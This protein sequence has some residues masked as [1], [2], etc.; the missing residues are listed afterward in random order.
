MTDLLKM[1]NCGRAYTGIDGM[2]VEMYLASASF[3]SCLARALLERARHLVQERRELAVAVETVVLVA[4]TRVEVLR[5]DLRVRRLE[6]REHHQIPVAGRKRRAEHH[7]TS[8]EPRHELDA[9]ALQLALDDLERQGAELVAR[10]RVEPERQ[11]AD[12]R[13]REDVAVP[14]RR[15]ARTAGA[16]LA[17]EQIDDGLLVERVL[18]PVLRVG[19]TRTA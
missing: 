7:A 3:R 1:M 8:L 18:R 11:L 2:S 9:D 10:R 14:G 12:A 17:L 19:R 6:I 13:A 4:T 15:L 16:A 5:R